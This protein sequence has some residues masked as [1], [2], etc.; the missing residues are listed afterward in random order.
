MLSLLGGKFKHCD[1]I[2]RRTFLTAGALGFG[3]L[4]LA[5]LLRAEAA[6]GI[7]SSNKAIINLS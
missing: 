6:A 3:G 5:N 7:G 4:T 1:G 2:T